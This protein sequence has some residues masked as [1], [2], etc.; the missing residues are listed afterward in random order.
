M[1]AAAKNLTPVTLELGGKS[2]VV[3]D[4]GVDLKT[5]SLRLMTGKLFNTGQ[6]CICPD[7]AFIPDDSV[8]PFLSELK[9][10]TA[11]LYPQHCRQP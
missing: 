6:I 3:I 1:C 9:K 4:K 11:S 5:V 8:V 10:A 2:P 7:Y